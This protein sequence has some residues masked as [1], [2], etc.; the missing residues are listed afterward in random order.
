MVAGDARDARVLLSERGVGLTL[1]SGAGLGPRD[2]TLT[3][4]TAL[5]EEPSRSGTI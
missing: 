2:S 3:A 4:L 5:E 1:A